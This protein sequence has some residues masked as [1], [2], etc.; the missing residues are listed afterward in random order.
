MMSGMKYPWIFGKRALM[1]SDVF[2]FY[3]RRAALIALSVFLSFLGNYDVAF[4]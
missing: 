1:M 3:V 4:G 2:A